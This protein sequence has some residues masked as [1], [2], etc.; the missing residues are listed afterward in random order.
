MPLGLVVGSRVWRSIA[1]F[2]PFQYAAPWAVGSLVL[3]PPA[4]LVIANLLAAW[5]ARR[6]AGATVAA[7]LRAE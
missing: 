1:G 5:P 6:A 4:A 7:T 3:I 2:T